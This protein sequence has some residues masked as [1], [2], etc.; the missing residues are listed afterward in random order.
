V[1]ESGKCWLELNS[2]NS[3]FG[4]PAH[5]QLS[6]ELFIK[7]VK[8]DTEMQFKSE[9]NT[10]KRGGHTVKLS[11]PETLRF[12]SGTPIFGADHGVTEMNKITQ[13]NGSKSKQKPHQ[14]LTDRPSPT[15]TR[16]ARSVSN[17]RRLRCTR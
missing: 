10:K 13:K 1:A 6:S 9:K 2:R 4:I 17:S 16:V 8:V 5:F 11:E 15:R 14:S 3:M 12:N 7:I